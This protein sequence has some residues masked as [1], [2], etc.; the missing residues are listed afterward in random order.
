VLSTFTARRAIAALAFVAALGAVLP[1]AWSDE[2][3]VSGD[4]SV[5]G[6]NTNGPYAGTAKVEKLKDGFYAIKIKYSPASGGTIDRLFV[7]KLDGKNLSGERGKSGGIISSLLGKPK[8]KDGIKVTYVL[9]ADGQKLDG[10]ISPSWRETLTKQVASSG[11]LL[12]D[13]NR[14]GKLDAADTNAMKTSSGLVVRVRNRPDA[15]KSPIRVVASAP[16][17]VSI[18]GTGQ[19]RIVDAQ[20]KDVTAPLPKGTHELGVVG[21]ADGDLDVVVAD[22]ATGEVK[23]RGRLSVQP[24]KLYVIMWGYEGT[25]IDYLEHDAAT[26]KSRLLPKILAAGYKMVEDGK[27]YDQTTIAKGLA[28]WNA[29]NKVVFDWCTTHEDWQ[30]YLERGTIRGLF[31]GSHGFMEPWTGCPDNELLQFESRVWTAPAG[32]PETTERKH[33]VREWKAFLDKQPQLDFAIMHSCC[34]GGL[35]TDY[36]AECWEYCDSGTQARVQAKFGSLPPVEKLD[37]SHSFGGQ[38][39]SNVTGQLQTFNGS[40][41]FGLSDVNWN[42]ATASIKP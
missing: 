10:Q 3:P 19:A 25:E 5:A 20:G 11:V 16:V 7:G 14:D 17:K 36:A 37:Q 38:L 12:V 41:Y 30:R 26:V 29:P 35:G 24:E 4:W 2:D 18:A 8:V 33:F 42:A 32:Q 34:T 39:K 21:T 23:A 31:W 28:D 15:V 40:S 22:A 27:G 9:S 13:A 6:S 1:R